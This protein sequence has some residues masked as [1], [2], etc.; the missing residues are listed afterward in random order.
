MRGYHGQW[1]PPPG[2]RCLVGSRSRLASVGVAFPIVINNLQEELT[3]IPIFRERQV[4]C[5]HQRHTAL[6]EIIYYVELPDYTSRGLV[7]AVLLPVQ[8]TGSLLMNPASR[9]GPPP[10]PPKLQGHGLDHV[11]LDPEGKV[12]IKEWSRKRQKLDSGSSRSENVIGDERLRRGPIDRI[13][14][15]LETIE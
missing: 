5:L 8:W 2:L 10:L 9:S 4:V 7:A 11:A 12:S 1:A 3:L 6:G 14:P 15:A 13:S